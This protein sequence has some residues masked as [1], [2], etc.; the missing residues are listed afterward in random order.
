MPQVTLEV[1]VDP[2]LGYANLTEKIA[3]AV[4]RLHVSHGHVVVQTMHT[5]TALLLQEDESGF[6]RDLQ[7]RVARIFPQ[8][9]ERGGEQWFE[10]YE[11]DDVRKRK[12]PQPDERQ[13]G[14]A[15]C[16]ASLFP[17]SITLSVECGKLVLGQWQ[18]ILFFDFDPAGRP[19]RQVRLMV[20]GM[21]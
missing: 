12:N 3:K 14:F 15:H 9:Y 21:P 18:Q 20:M 19:P 13:N 5:T 17:A 16:R 1:S 10:Y 11:H 6:I 8:H 2:K 4:C 7:T